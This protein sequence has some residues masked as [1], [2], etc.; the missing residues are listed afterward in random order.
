MIVLGDAPPT[1]ADAG[2]ADAET[3][4][5]PS[6]E[7]PAWLEQA[8]AKLD[9]KD[10]VDANAIAPGTGLTGHS[11][12]ESA[13]GSPASAPVEAVTSPD[14]P[15]A[16][17]HAPAL[18]QV[19]ATGVL[20]DMLATLD[21]LAQ[22]AVQ[23]AVPPT[24]A[25]PSGA[26]AFAAKGQKKQRRR[27]AR[28]ASTIAAAARAR[29]ARIRLQNLRQAV[30]AITATRRAI[31]IRRRMT[32]YGRACEQQ[33]LGQHVEWRERTPPLIDWLRAGKPK[34]INL[35]W[36]GARGLLLLPPQWQPDDI[37]VFRWPAHVELR[38]PGPNDP[39]D[40]IRSRLRALATDVRPHALP[41]MRPPAPRPLPWP[42][43]DGAD[44]TAEDEGGGLD[45]RAQL[46]ALEACDADSYERG[47]GHGYSRGRG[48]DDDGRDWD[49]DG[50]YLDYEQGYDQGY[51]VGR[52]VSLRAQD[53]D[54]AGPDP[55]GSVHDSWYDD[56]EDGEGAE[57]DA[58][59]ESH[60]QV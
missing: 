25:P 18:S 16:H 59:F 41:P 47:Y 42:D 10:L 5:L 37:L 14:M 28:A 6:A 60:Y 23:P 20:V 22:P 8:W 21:T 7:E 32:A 33:R 4:A 3:D 48:P 36:G 12:G 44:G 53:G 34:H 38:L 9:D 11:D 50:G 31:V 26:G 29:P 58:W 55:G 57:Y 19:L 52:H 39:N 56:G 46:H 2:D 54:D 1:A 49:D 24:A 13:A 45:A 30:T 15:P 27:A 51:D 17:E 35:E 40:E 43:D